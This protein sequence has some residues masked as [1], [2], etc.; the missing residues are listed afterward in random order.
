MFVVEPF[1]RKSGIRSALGF[2]SIATK[3]GGYLFP[4]LTVLT[5]DLHDVHAMRLVALK[6]KKRDPDLARFRTRRS[7]DQI[8]RELDSLLR[9]EDLCVPADHLKQKTS[10][11]IRYG[12]LLDHFGLLEETKPRSISYYKSLI[13]ERRASDVGLDDLSTRE[14]RLRHF[15]W[16]QKNRSRL[17]PGGPL[18]RWWLTGERP[19]RRAP[20]ALLLVREL[21]FFFVVWQTLFETA[22]RL[23]HANERLPHSGLSQGDALKCFWDCLRKLRNRFD[24]AVARR[25]VQ[26]SFDLHKTKVAPRLKRWT[27]TVDRLVAEPTKFYTL[28][29]GQ[30]IETLRKLRGF[31][32]LERLAHL[33]V[34]Y[35]KQQGKRHAISI[36]D[37]SHGHLG[38]IDPP[39][40]LLRLG[41]EG[42]LFGYRLEA[43]FTLHES[44][45][46]NRLAER[47]AGD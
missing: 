24:V 45:K 39:I 10:Y 26:A 38:P 7:D 28:H 23:L 9:S 11:W 5:R 31:R 17:G 22:A 46:Y 34:A 41:F 1:E 30:P 47:R 37:F 29:D 4:G 43:A 12:S 2:M 14:R 18:Q 27:R 15:R 8:A 35:C 44:R 3:W 6:N 13:F 21:E 36:F 20:P 40:S 16:Y 33:H 19:P 25:L 32:L 42:G